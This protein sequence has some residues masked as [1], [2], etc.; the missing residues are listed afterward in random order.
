MRYSS[1]IFADD[2]LNIIKHEKELIDIVVLGSVEA[3]LWW[4]K[5]NDE[6]HLA[7]NNLLNSDGSTTVD[8]IYEACKPR[9]R[10][11]DIKVFEKLK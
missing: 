7:L 4:N 6:G 8:E 10:K 3:E 5:I 11:E 1:E 2:Y 9:D